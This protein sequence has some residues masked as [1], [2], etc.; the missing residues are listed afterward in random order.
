MKRLFKEQDVGEFFRWVVVGIFATIVHYGI[1]WL[2]KDL[3]NVNLAYTIGYALSFISNFALT[4]FFTFKVNPTIQ[5][6]IGL[7]LAHAINYLLQ[8]GLL[9][10]F[11]YLGVSKTL[12]PF[13]TFMISVPINFL[14]VRYVFKRPS[15]KE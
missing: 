10:L 15:K 2:L 12:A 14:M 11:L 1:Y 8:L 5:K 6:G 9:N 7:A 4:S 13:P 3:M